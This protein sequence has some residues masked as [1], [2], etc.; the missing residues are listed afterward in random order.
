MGSIVSISKLFISVRPKRQ[1]LIRRVCQSYSFLGK[2]SQIQKD[3]FCW[4]VQKSKWLYCKTCIAH[5]S[6]MSFICIVVLISTTGIWTKYAKPDRH[7]I[8][9]KFEVSC[10]SDSI[11]F[12]KNRAPIFSQIRILYL[13]I[14]TWSRRR[15]RKALYFSEWVKT[16]EGHRSN[17]NKYSGW[18]IVVSNSWTGFWCNWRKYASLKTVTDMWWDLKPNSVFHAYHHAK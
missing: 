12:S 2:I 10:S 13:L 4:V 7:V 14:N 9:N 11:Y 3:I 15:M 1:E 5:R 8:T 18:P 6:E 16:L 17:A